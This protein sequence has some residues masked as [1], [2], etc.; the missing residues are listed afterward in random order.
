MSHPIPENLSAFGQTALTL[1]SEF[2][3]FGKFVRELENL[4]VLS[5]KG[6]ERGCTLIDEINSSRQNI[7]RGMQSLG[8]T[9]SELRARNEENEKTIAGCSQEVFKRHG[10]AKQMFERLKQLGESVSQIN[11]TASELRNKTKPDLGDADRMEISA[12][13]SH[14]ENGLDAIINEAKTLVEQARVANMKTLEHSAD[15]LRKSLT[16]ARNRLKLAAERQVRDA[17]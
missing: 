4:S 13:I 16:D 15:A 14:L 8:K 17:S 3:K 7:E 10:E 5:D 9:L 1:D 2:S 6:L 11:V 12:Q